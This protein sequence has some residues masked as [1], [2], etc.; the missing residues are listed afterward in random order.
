MLLRG[1]ESS[2]ISDAIFYVRELYKI[3]RVLGTRSDRSNS[4]GV[5]QSLTQQLICCSRMRRV[6]GRPMCGGNL[7]IRQSYSKEDVS[8]VLETS[9]AKH[10]TVLLI[11]GNLIIIYQMKEFEELNE[12]DG[13]LS[14]HVKRAEKEQLALSRLSQKV[15]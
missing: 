8:K 3:E 9:K 2:E 7:V 14:N 15:E 5:C 11:V 1:Q 10:P 4:E 6:K 12:N 13:D